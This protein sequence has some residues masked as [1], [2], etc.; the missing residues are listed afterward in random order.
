MK[1]PDPETYP[2]LSKVTDPAELRKL[3]VE[4][5]T[6]LAKEVRSFLL[7]TVSQ[8]SGHLAS[9]LGVV[10]LT[11]AAPLRLQHAIRQHCGDVLHHRPIPTR[12]SLVPRRV[13]GHNQEAL[14]YLHSFP[15]RGE[16]PYDTAS[17][18]HASTSIGIALGMAVAADREGK[19]R[20]TCAVIGDGAM[21]GGIAFEALNHAGSLGES[22]LV[23]LNDNE[24]SI[25]EPVGALLEVPLLH[26]LLNANYISIVKSD[27]NLPKNFPLLQRRVSPSRAT[28]TSRA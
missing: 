23:V 24:M 26:P 25:S 5:L 17:V 21:T 6:A 28:S 20:K 1:L 14:G 10:E 2:L 22:L 12:S 11:I 18:G 19:G 4:D 16:S 8:T 3:S 15:W 27:K 7:R 13:H 9:G